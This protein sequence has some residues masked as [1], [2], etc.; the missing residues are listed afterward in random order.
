M[1]PQPAKSPADDP[2][3]PIVTCEECHGSGLEIHLQCCGEHKVCCRQPEANREVC[4]ACD[5][6]GR[7][8]EKRQ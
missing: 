4:S 1:T 2:I 6:K 7:W 8:K 3:E 5:G